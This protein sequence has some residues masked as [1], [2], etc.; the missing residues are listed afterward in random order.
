[1]NT[2]V[3]KKIG[4]KKLATSYGLKYNIIEILLYLGSDQLLCK[5]DGKLNII[6]SRDLSYSLNTYD[7]ADGLEEVELLLDTSR[8]QPKINDN[9]P[10]KAKKKTRKRGRPK[11][12]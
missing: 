1:M 5:C 12:S 9:K 10:D 6:N 8:P 11:K 2:I 7:F 3:L 4:G